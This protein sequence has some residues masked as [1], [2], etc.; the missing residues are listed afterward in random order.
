MPL[1][2]KSL[3]VVSTINAP[4]ILVIDGRDILEILVSILYQSS[5][6]AEKNLLLNISCKDGITCSHILEIWESVNDSQCSVVL[7][8]E[9]RV[10]AVDV[11]KTWE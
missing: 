6:S 1:Q 10:A 5:G 8:I 2:S 3:E 4:A 7:D 9:G 11:C